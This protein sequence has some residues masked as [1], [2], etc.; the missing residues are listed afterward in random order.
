MPRERLNMDLVK[1]QVEN[2]IRTTSFVYDGRAI[3]AP[4]SSFAANLNGISKSKLYY[5][6]G[7]YPAALE[8]STGL[9]IIHHGWVLGRPE[10]VKIS[11]TVP[12]PENFE[13]ILRDIE[14]LT[15]EARQQLIARLAIEDSIS[16]AE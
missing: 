1:A 6:H 16:S 2:A 3:L 4:E 10:Y 8:T 5:A 15:P 11:E 7:G 9:T 13:T 12:E 14:N